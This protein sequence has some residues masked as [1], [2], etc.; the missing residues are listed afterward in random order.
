MTFSYLKNSCCYR[1]AI[2]IDVLWMS[3]PDENLTNC[4]FLVQRSLQAFIDYHTMLSLQKRERERVNMIMKV[5]GITKHFFRK[6]KQNFS[7]LHKIICSLVSLFLFILWKL[8][9]SEKFLQCLITSV[10]VS[11]KLI[12]FLK[13]NIKFN[14]LSIPMKNFFS[15][16][17]SFW[18]NNFDFL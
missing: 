13:E 4:F 11:Y 2:S 8:L 10:L 9:Q 3:F 16:R 7:S 14:K 1:T 17:H 5:Q 12:S 6:G 15:L 18:R